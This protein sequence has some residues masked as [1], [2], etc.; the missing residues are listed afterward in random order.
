MKVEIQNS[1]NKGLYTE[2]KTEKPVTARQVHAIEKRMTEI[3][4]EDIPFV[5]EV[6]SREEAMDI[7]AQD[8][9]KEKQRILSE[10]L[11]L[12]QVKFY[13]LNGVRA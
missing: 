6:V 9:L 7:L 2:I 4:K 12:N 1:L 13:S 8:G 5:K 10:S 3:V 11:D